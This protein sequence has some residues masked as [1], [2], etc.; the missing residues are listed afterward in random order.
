MESEEKKNDYPFKA[1]DLL[2]RIN[3]KSESAKFKI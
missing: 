2:F 3:S 1:G